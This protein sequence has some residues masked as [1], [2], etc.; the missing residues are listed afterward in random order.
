[1][2]ELVVEKRAEH[3]DDDACLPEAA[4]L[5]NSDLEEARIDP[6]EFWRHNA[7]SL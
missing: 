7:E 3:E 2:N 6:K 1:M 4:D 5:V